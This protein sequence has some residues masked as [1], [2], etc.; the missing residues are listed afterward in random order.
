MDIISTAVAGK[1]KKI[2]ESKVQHYVS[3]EAG[4]PTIGDLNEGDTWLNTDTGKVMMVYSGLWVEEPQKN[5]VIGQS[6]V[7]TAINDAIAAND[8]TDQNYAI[9]MAIALG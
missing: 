5:I 8:T 4:R 1:A 7:T 2:A 3:D 6:D 9:Q